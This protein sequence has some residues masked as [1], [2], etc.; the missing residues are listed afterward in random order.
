MK[1]GKIN[2]IGKT[3]HCLAMALKIIFSFLGISNDRIIPYHKFLGVDVNQDVSNLEGILHSLIVEETPEEFIE[4]YSSAGITIKHKYKMNSEEIDEL[5]DNNFPIFFMIDTYKCHWSNLYKKVHFEHVCLIEKEINGIYQLIDPM[6]SKEKVIIDK[7]NIE[8]LGKSFFQIVDWEKEISYCRVFFKEMFISEKYKRN[9]VQS[10]QFAQMLK[11]KREYILKNFE[12]NNLA[13]MLIANYFN[14]FAIQQELYSEFVNRCVEENRKIWPFFDL[15]MKSIERTKSV[16][17]AF[18]RLGLCNEKKKN[19]YFD[20][21][22]EAL[23]LFNQNE[24]E[25]DTCLKN[26]LYIQKTTI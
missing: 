23:Y 16:S 24:I 11:N 19:E 12:M 3:N 4:S 21:L 15:L 6:F 8:F 9:Q 2:E 14:Q 13:A 1:Y 17:Y 10:N 18:M 7:K 26:I 5:L 25:K 20:K 22:L